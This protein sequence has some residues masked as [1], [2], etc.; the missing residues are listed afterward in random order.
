M[1]SLTDHKVPID[2][3]SLAA[4][5]KGIGFSVGDTKIRL[6]DETKATSITLFL[7]PHDG[8][9]PDGFAISGFP[10]VL[11]AEPPVARE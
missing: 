2:D 6:D 9:E 5:V 10:H 3:V 7:S 1:Y 8:L 4:M 11:L